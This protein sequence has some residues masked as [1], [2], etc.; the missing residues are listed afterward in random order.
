MGGVGGL[1]SEHDLGVGGQ[2]D[3]AHPGAVIGERHPAQLGVVF[4]GDHHL[5]PAGDRAVAADDLRT[6]LGEGDL[7]AVRLDAARLVARRPDLAALHIAKEEIGP[8]AVA[9]GVFPEAGD[10]DVANAGARRGAVEAA[11]PGARRGDHQRV[12]AVA[13]EMAARHRL[14]GGR[15]AAHHRRRQIAGLHGGCDL[16]RPRPG[17]RHVARRALLEQQLGR[18]HERHRMEAGRHAAVLAHVEDI[19]ER[20][21]GHPLVMRHVGAHHREVL[22]LRQAH[23]RVVDR[24]IEAEAAGRSCLLQL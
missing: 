22:P 6:I 9:G 20:E 5:Q 10:G 21:E 15:E 23:R 16:F 4:L 7:V 11:V 17:D 12:A 8:P 2:L 3:L 19:G 14:V 1:R 13:E 24:L 18:L